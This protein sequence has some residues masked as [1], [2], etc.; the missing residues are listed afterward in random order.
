MGDK[1]Q[2]VALCTLNDEM[3]SDEATAITIVGRVSDVGENFQNAAFNNKPMGENMVDDQTIIN[4]LREGDT[5]FEMD[6][7]Y[8]IVAELLEDI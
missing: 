5:S 1:F 6:E 4:N 3:L 8:S 2:N 7:E